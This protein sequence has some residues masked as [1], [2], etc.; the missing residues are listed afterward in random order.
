MTGAFPVTNDP[1]FAH[2]SSSKFFSS[3][4]HE[5]EIFEVFGVHSGI[6]KDGYECSPF[7]DGVAVSISNHISGSTTTVY[8]HCRDFLFNQFTHGTDCV[9]STF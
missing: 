6:Y 4:K 8:H 2:K 7:F 3:A 9:W 1:R 5:L